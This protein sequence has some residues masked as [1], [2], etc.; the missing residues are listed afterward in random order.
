MV[1]TT[2]DSNTPA[3]AAARDE[4][5]GARSA[6]WPDAPGRIVLSRP[7]RVRKRNHRAQRGRSRPAAQRRE[8]ALCVGGTTGPLTLALW[9]EAANVGDGRHARKE[10]RAMSQHTNR[11]ARETSPYLRQHAHNPVDWYP[12]GP[13]AFARA[14]KED[15]PILLSIG[16]SACHWCHVMERESFADEDT[17]RLM[18]ELFVNIKV[19]RE[20]RPDIDHIY[21]TAVQLLTGR[22][23]WPLTVFLCPDGRPFLGGTYFPPVDR[24]GLPAFRRVLLAVA[25]AYREKRDDIATTA[26]QLVEALQ[27]VETPETADI[28]CDRALLD[29]AAARLASL[30]DPT[31][32][33]LAPAP[34][35]PNTAVF[36]YFLQYAMLSG[37]PRYREMV[38]HTLVRMARGGIFDQ[39][40]GGF[41]RYSVDE[42]W[43]V[44]HFEKMLYDNA[45]LARLY[46]L[47]YQATHRAEFA[48]VARDTLAYLLRELRSPEGGFYS[49]QDADSEGEEGKYYVWTRQEVLD[50]LGPELGELACRYWDM[51]DVGNFEHHTNVLHVTLEPA[52]LARLTGRTED[53]VTA[54]LEQARQR[55]FAARQQRVPPARDDKILTA[56]NALA[57][58]AFAL[59]SEVLEDP[60]YADTVRQTLDFVETHL[61]LADGLRSTFAAGVAKYPAHLDDMAFLLTAYLDAFE[62]LQDA[63]HL[64]RAERLAEELLHHFWD[65]ERPGFFFTSDHHDPLIVRSKPAFDGAIPSGNSAACRALQRLARL[66]GKVYGEH[67]AAM[68][69]TYATTVRAQPSGFA[70]ML[71]AAAFAVAPPCEIVVVEAERGAGASLAR[72]VRQHYVPHRVLIV[73]SPGDGNEHLPLVA[74][75]NLPPTAAAAAYVCRGFTCLPPVTDAESL[76]ALLPRLGNVGLPTN[77]N[78]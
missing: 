32:G 73:A 52:G 44:P 1:P 67:A 36:E 28:P 71:C 31:Y 12:W 48:R 19:D 8:P 16:Y 64:E 45:L 41:H 11:L 17:A 53:E 6:R 49:S 66:T 30:Y 29:E 43:L 59:A 33:G 7:R 57:V 46:L 37:D 9:C 54:A 62:A 39:I 58:S 68:L 75:K 10:D 18:N 55:L 13:E 35:F 38:E 15:K 25:R 76:A 78:A 69:A 4:R 77:A 56:W 40:G 5:A 74:G 27:R 14:Q 72:T 23:G 51:T 24:H 60:V 63:R 3:H 21:M 34:K 47:A 26:A 20:E 65:R 2:S 70:N 50:V 61:W 22:G 42:R